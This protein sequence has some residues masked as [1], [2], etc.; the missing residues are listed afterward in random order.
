[1]SCT[2]LSSDDGIMSSDIC[3]E[4]QWFSRLSNSFSPFVGCS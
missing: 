3:I 2:A 1:V 4:A